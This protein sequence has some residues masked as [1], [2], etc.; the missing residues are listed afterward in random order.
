MKKKMVD[1]MMAAATCAA[2]MTACG[3]TEKPA[4]QNEVQEAAPAEE[5]STAA[6]GTSTAAEEAAQTTAETDPE[7]TYVQEPAPEDATYAQESSV[8]PSYAEE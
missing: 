2:L 3:G 1:L 8:D 4:A 6:E 5:T 7:L